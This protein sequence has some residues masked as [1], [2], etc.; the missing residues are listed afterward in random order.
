MR[1]HA[2]KSR[3]I[4]TTYRLQADVPLI[5][6]KIVMKTLSTVAAAA[7]LVLGL[8]SGVQ[9]QSFAPQVPNPANPT[10][11]NPVPTD[12]SSIPNFGYGLRTGRSAFVG[13]AIT[14][15]PNAVGSF[16]IGR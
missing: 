16:V 7:T 12:G 14:A 5:R 10:P 3:A 6:K 4:E 11:A 15:V 8:A 9:A 13:D 2:F 1:K